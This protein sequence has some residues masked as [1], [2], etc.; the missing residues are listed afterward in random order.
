[1]IYCIIPSRGGSKGI[2]NKNIIDFKGKPLML[3]TID[4]ALVLKQKKLIHEIYVSSDSD[5]ILSLAK[6]SEVK[7]IKRPPD[8]STS[9]SKTVDAIVHLLKVLSKKNEYPTAILTLQ[10]TSPF[11]KIDDF[12]S[13]ISLFKKSNY[14]SLISV[15]Y[16][17][18]L[19][20]S[21]L[22]NP[23]K[24]NFCKPL[25]SSHNVGL[26]RQDKKGLLIRNGSLYLTKV[27]YLIKNRVL[28]CDKPKYIIMSRLNSINID[29][30]DD[31]D[32]ARMI[33][34]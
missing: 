7:T 10:P 34:K 25:I 3:H 33:K 11:R 16:D 31:L 23:L 5:K 29:T 1:M 27:E 19:N 14:N 2:K 17:E 18:A 15:Y 28:V 24:G 9:K 6:K 8:L 30:Q 21:I 32:F 26:R 12:E 4:F 20:N 13:S 22:Y